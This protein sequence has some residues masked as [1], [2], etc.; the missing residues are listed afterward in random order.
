MATSALA[1]DVGAGVARP[2]R[3]AVLWGIGLAGCAAAGS[4]VALAMESDHVPDPVLRAIMVDWIVIPY[5][6]AGVVAW[7]RRPE[8]RFGPLLV[9]AGLA[10]F[11]SHLSWSSLALPY[12][13]DIPYTIGLTFALLPPVLFL[14]V[15]LAFPSG[16]LERWFERVLLAAAYLTAIGLDLVVMT[17]TGK[18]ITVGLGYGLGI[19][20]TGTSCGGWGHSGEL[21]GYDVSSAFSENGRRQAVL[22]INQDASTLPKPAYALYNRLM[23]KAFC[24][25]A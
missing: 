3:P 19:G 12:A 6:L 16:R 25:G 23:D 13:I 7:W 10:A 8:S 1:L 5:I 18:V 11:L 9:A 2:P 14:H 20:R 24:A 4:T 17:F 15:F 22:M 21:P